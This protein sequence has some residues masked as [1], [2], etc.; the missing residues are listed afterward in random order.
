IQALL[1]L[2]SFALM[3]GLVYG[4]FSNPKADIKYSKNILFSNH[5]KLGK[6][7]QVRIANKN[8]HHLLKADARIL[9]LHN[10][11]K[12]NKL[13]KEYKELELTLN[14]IY[15]LPLNWT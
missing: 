9:L 3:S 6:T 14:H 2:M 4:R 15:F 10:K 5:P 13:V 1:G 7:L 11:T 12:D 8:S